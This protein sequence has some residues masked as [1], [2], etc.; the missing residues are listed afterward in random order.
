MIRILSHPATIARKR[1]QVVERLLAEE[2]SV[3]G[4]LDWNRARS[5]LR[6]FRHWL[7]QKEPITVVTAIML[8]LD[9]QW[10]PVS[11]AMEIIAPRKD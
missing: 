4:L 1:R 7:N 11:E 2:R 8:N 9:S 6:Q 5:L 3:V 10:E